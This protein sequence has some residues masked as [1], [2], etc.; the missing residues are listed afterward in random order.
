MAHDHMSTHR[1]RRLSAVPLIAFTLLASALAL[2]QLLTAGAADSGAPDTAGTDFWL[3]FPQNYADL[4]TLTL[5][6]TGS[7]ATSGSAVVGGDTIPFTVTPGTVTSVPIPATAQLVSGGGV[8]DKGIHV[9][10]VDDVTV[11]GLNRYQYTTDAYLGLPT[12]ILGTEY[13]VLGSAPAVGTSTGAVVATQDA[14]TVTITPTAG[15]L[16]GEVAG[17][18]FDVSL[19]AGQTYEFDSSSGDL[20][21]SLVTATKPIGVYGG[22]TCANIPSTSYS[23]CDHI[24]EQLPPVTAWGKSFLTVPLATRLNGDTF[25]LV[26]SENATVVNVNGAPVAT[27]DRGQVH[28]QIIDGNSTISADKPILV[29]QYSNGSSFDG[30]TSDP[31]EMLVPPTEQYLPSYTVTTP[32]DGFS[33]NFL[34]LVVP[35]DAIPSVT[36]DGVA[37]PPAEFTPIG[38]SGFSGAKVA[39]ELGSHTVA[40]S[41]PLGLFAYGFA[42][43]DSYGYPGGSSLAP[44]ATVDSLTLAPATQTLATGASGSVVA[45]LQDSNDAPVVG[46]R[47]DFTVAGANPGTGFAFTDAAGNASF[48][49]TGVVAGS[50]TITATQGSLTATA[51]ITWTGT[52]PDNTTPVADA[53][54]VTT[55][56]DTPVGVTLSG[57]DA[58]SDPLTFA[59][60]TQP[61]NGTLSGTAPDLTY[62]PNAGYFG[63]DSFTYTANDGTV[64]SDPATV[65]ITVNEVVPPDGCLVTPATVG[66]SVSRD[67]SKDTRSL[68]SPKLTTGGGRLLVAF[69]GA[70]GQLGRTQEVTGVTGGGLT[71][72]LA[73]KANET[74]GTTEVWYAVAPAAV[75]DVRV[76]A[77]LRRAYHGTI[78]VVAFDGASGIGAVGSASGMK[79][80]P[81]VT[82]TPTSCGSSLWAAGHDWSKATRPEPVDGQ[83]VFTKFIDRTVGD[84]Y[85]TSAVD[86]PTETT[87]PV[88]I[89]VTGPRKDLWTYAAVEILGT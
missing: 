14:T 72:T 33:A 52:P 29:A 25:R 18:A 71:W 23:A 80:A 17:A 16:T 37:V 78:T 22:N 26:A 36:V 68:V 64:D 65:S 6:V 74:W 19:N 47:V 48:S 85:W 30:V 89:K 54:S 79:G 61:T 59:V 67:F 39:V 12:D 5:F 69:I 1:R 38:S 15:L 84:S 66:E 4:P 44:V 73:S 86:A 3:A 27:L 57:S 7:T 41:K 35:T 77:K 9:T 34:N 75:S 81:E 50:D 31:F 58:D 32:A 21:G 46:V 51:T 11:Y 76:E 62:T 55:D 60:A 40:A 13:F 56:E 45:T 28:E 49:Y 20:S 10:A 83:S 24:V 43:Y 2:P 82:V 8:E 87:D 70:D 88:T 53:K 63:P 42:S